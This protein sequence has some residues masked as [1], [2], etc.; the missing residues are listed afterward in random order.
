[1][2]TGKLRRNLQLG[3]ERKRGA[4]RF[5]HRV[6]LALK[7]R[8]IGR[9][10]QL[11]GGRAEGACGLFGFLGKCHLKILLWTEKLRPD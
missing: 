11:V 8:Q 7:V 10:L 4:Y 3:G 9:F 6:L 5:K 1:M 2:K